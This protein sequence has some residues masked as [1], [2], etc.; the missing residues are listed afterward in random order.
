M[1]I[2]DR[3]LPEAGSLHDLHHDAPD[4]HSPDSL[5]D[6]QLHRRVHYAPDS[7][8]Y[9]PHGVTVHF[10]SGSLHDLHHDSADM[11]AQGAVHSLPSGLRNSYSHTHQMCC[12]P[13]SNDTDSLR[14]SSRVPNCSLLRSFVQVMVAVRRQMPVARAATSTELCIMLRYIDRVVSGPRWN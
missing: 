1:L 5:H 2:R 14:S 11:H 3:N 10:T 13:G 9:L 7:I 12:S 8:H 6:M 4:M